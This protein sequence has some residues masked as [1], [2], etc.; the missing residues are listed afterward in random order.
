MGLFKIFSSIHNNDI[1]KHE[2]SIQ[3]TTT[4]EKEQKQD[5]SAFLLMNKL[6]QEEKQELINTYNRLNKFYNENNNEIIDNSNLNTFTQTWNVIKKDFYNFNSNNSLQYLTFLIKN[7]SIVDLGKYEWF[8]EMLVKNESI[9]KRIL[10]LLVERI[11]SKANLI[12]ITDDKINTQ[13]VLNIYRLYFDDIRNIIKKTEL[14]GGLYIVF[15]EGILK[16]Y[17]P[18]RLKYKVN[19]Q[20]NTRSYDKLFYLNK[21]LETRIF[22]KEWLKENNLEY[23]DF[24]DGSRYPYNRVFLFTSTHKPCGEFYEKTLQGLGYSCFEGNLHH[25]VEIISDLE[26]L[27]KQIN[28]QNRVSFRVKDYNITTAMASARQNIN[29]KES[30]EKLFTTRSTDG[31]VTDV[32]NQ[33]EMLNSQIQIIDIIDNACFKLISFIWGIPYNELTQNYSYFNLNKNL[34]EEEKKKS[35]TL[36]SN[37]LSYQQKINNLLYLLLDYYGI[38]K[39]NE[40]GEQSAITDKD[41]YLSLL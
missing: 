27:H 8:L 41:L 22:N 23:I 5:D 34:A 13:Q 19:T 35:F 28:V 16:Q 32:E 12:T 39:T 33:V 11:L 40:L 14:Y 15:E 17:Q 6:N 25:L 31:F 1:K 26:S 21:Q 2:S 20:N 9:V 29:L 4:E 24:T 30:V 18:S 10:E 38:K 37:K 3:P 7:E 36:N